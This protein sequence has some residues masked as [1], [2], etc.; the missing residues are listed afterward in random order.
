[1][2]AETRRKSA[3]RLRRAIAA[4]RRVK[5]LVLDVDGVLTDG[6]LSYGPD[7]S[8]S[9]RFD[10]QDGL[11]IKLF[12]AAGLELAAITGLDS[13]AVASRVRELGVVEYFPGF[14]DKGVIL[15]EL[16]ARK[17][18]CFEEAAFLGDDWVDA[19]VGLPMAVPEAQPEIRRLAL[20]T[21]SRSGGRGA[22][23][24][25]A[26]FILSAQGRLEEFWFRWGLGW[27]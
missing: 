13:P 16:L 4:A 3:S 6:G 10:V 15:R 26:R 7:G 17:N 22:A 19:G 12:Q 23:R 21:S 27:R 2:R 25:A 9:K 5:L 8:I 11:G 18:L 24:E 14:R 20:W 1:M